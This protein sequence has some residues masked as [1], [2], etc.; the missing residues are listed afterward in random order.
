[1]KNAGIGIIAFTGWLIIAI[2]FLIVIW[3]AGVFSALIR[4]PE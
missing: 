1:M 3:I 2:P 4:P